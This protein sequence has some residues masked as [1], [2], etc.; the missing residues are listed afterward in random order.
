MQP[1]GPRARKDGVLAE[2]KPAARH[3]R[4]RRS[5][6]SVREHHGRPIFCL[7]F[8]T[9]DA[10]HQRLLATVGANQVRVRRSAA[11]V[12]ASHAHLRRQ[13][14]RWP[15]LE[16]LPMACSRPTRARPPPPPR[17]LCTSAS[18]AAPWMRCRRTSQQTCV[19][20]E[21]GSEAHLARGW[22]DRLQCVPAP[23]A[24]EATPPPNLTAH[25]PTLHQ[26]PP[27]SPGRSFLWLSGAPTRSAARRCC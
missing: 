27:T 26:H 13:L 15:W 17:R 16:A 7:K 21:H 14:R 11:C 19:G 12:I 2:C 20:A 22:R 5:T 10:A 18:P 8:N 23:H 9:R 6:P 1:R 3:A 25:E 24:C 4:R